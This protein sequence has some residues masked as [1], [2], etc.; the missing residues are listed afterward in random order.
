MTF[1]YPG[2]ELIFVQIDRCRDVSAHLLSYIFKFFSSKTGYN[3]ILRAEY[4]SEDV[5]AVKF[6][7]KKDKRSRFKYHKIV[8]KGDVGNIFITCL[9]VIPILLQKYP[10]ASFGIC[11]SPTIDFK[12]KMIENYANNQRFRTYCY[13]ISLKIGTETFTHYDYQNVS[14]YLLLNNKNPDLETKENLIIKMFSDTYHELSI[15]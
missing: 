7:C 14:S 10:T 9:K 12:S 1:D 13:V 2:Y 6:Y 11:G 3:Y 8:N 5:F 4:H 15:D